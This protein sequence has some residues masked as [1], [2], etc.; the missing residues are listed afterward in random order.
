MATAPS[1]PPSFSPRRKWAI[2]L[3]VT[4]LITLVLAVVVMVNYLSRDY[5]ARFH[6]STRNKIELS[7]LTLKFL[8]SLT[9]RVKVTLYYNRDEP[10]YNSVSALLNEYRLVNPRI[11]IESIDYL[12]DASAAQRIKSQYKLSLPTAT[13]LVIF[14]CEGRPMVVDGNALTRYVLEPM[15]NEQE[16]EFRRKPV[17]FRGEQMFTAALLAVSSA[18][19][20]R[21]YFLEG[22]GEHSID[23]DD[24]D[25]G[26]LNFAAITRQNNIEPRPLSLVGTNAIPPDCHLLVIA[27]AYREV[28]VP[29]LEK[30]EQYLDQGGRLLLLFNFLSVNRETGLEKIV[31]RWG[32]AVGE[33]IIKDPSTVSGADVLVTA[34]SK[35][36]LVNPLLGLTLEMVEPRSLGTLAT[37][38][39][40]SA[41]APLV[42]QVAFSSAKSYATN[43]PSHLRQ[44]P[45]IVAVEKGA[46]KGAIAER[47]ATRIIVA[48]DSLFLAN[49][50]FGAGANRDFAG[51]ALN[52][53]LDRTQLLNGLGPRPITEWRL[54]TTPAQL[55]NLRWIVLG[56]MPAGT[57][58]VGGLVWL[59]RRK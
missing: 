28:P 48:G 36:A 39:A 54:I 24:K 47:G 5:F 56:A 43:D 41:N 30:I 32:V 16:R 49:H 13:N 10:F 44:F 3:N 53:L 57:L 22:H 51:Y 33:N 4:L 26:Y 25:Y 14:E 40:P 1:P 35:H 29:E 6:W 37:S 55:N 8:D 50:L 31:A 19:P 42:E 21:A 2:G 52:W 20:L 45:L 58:L 46:L 17:E 18:K 7:P 9:N 59:R 12:R 34:F 11:S 15:T 23:S 38:S 27:G